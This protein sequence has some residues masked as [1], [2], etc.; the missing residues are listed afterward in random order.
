MKR[1]RLF[2]L[3]LAGL[4]LSVFFLYLKT[5]CSSPYPD[6]SPETAAV[7]ALLGVGHPPGYP[8]HVLLGHLFSCFLGA[9]GACLA[10]G[11]AFFL[12]SPPGVGAWDSPSFPAAWAGALL[13]GGLLALGPVYW[14][15]A[16]LAKGSVYLLD[17]DFTLALLCVARAGGGAGAARLFWLLMGLALANHYMTQVLLLPAYLLLPWGREGKGRLPLAAAAWALPGLSLWAYLPLRAACHPAV[18]WGGIHSL[19]GWADYMARRQYLPME[20]TRGLSGSL[21]VLAGC[22]RAVLL[23]AG[24]LGCLAG[25]GGLVL[26]WR[27]A[28]PW[29]GFWLAC[30]GLFSVVPALYLNLP[31]RAIELARYYLFPAYL[32]AALLAGMFLARVLERGRVRAWLAPLLAAGL[33]AQALALAPGLG[34]AGY[35][36]GWDY[37]RNLML[38]APRGG[39]LFSES[40]AALFESWYF[41][42]WRGLRPDLAVVPEP[43]L[44]GRWTRALLAR[45]FPEILQPDVEVVG[46][47]SRLPVLLGFL[48]LNLGRRFVAFSGPLELPGYCMAPLGLL[49]LPWPGDRPPR[50][51]DGGRR[52][53]NLWRAYCLRGLDRPSPDETTGESIFQFYRRAEQAFGDLLAANHLPDAARRHWRLAARLGR[54]S[55]PPPSPWWENIL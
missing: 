16:L 11:L 30:L 54:E 6:D 3:G 21:H 28:L 29:R 44:P 39:L 37:G 19:A 40:D 23:Q 25:L 47:D 26:A 32:C 48:K 34:R 35:Y 15:E 5:C 38:G 33:L 12:A 42:N 18:N 51:S 8:L 13:A 36:Y 41:Q 20:V 24:A 31:G 55:V 10:A 50:L 7:C 53:E 17:A 49:S 45:R 14:G 1:R 52:L 46:R 27:R 43:M 4:F 22:G 2:A 9:L